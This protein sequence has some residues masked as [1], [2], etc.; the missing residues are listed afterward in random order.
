MSDDPQSHDEEQPEV[1]GGARGWEQPGAPAH[2]PQSYLAP[3]PPHQQPWVQQQPF[4]QYQ[5]QQQWGAAPA[6]YVDYVVYRPVK[7]DGFCVTS[8]ILGICSVTIGFCIF[9]ATV[10]LGIM[11]IVFGILGIRRVRAAPE[12]ST[13]SGLAIAGISLGSIIV[14]LTLLFIGLIVL[15]D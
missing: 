15:A 14:V 5:P 11:A 10:I 6:G 7:T 9:P 2:P 13:G 4:Q 3:P 12:S 8:I 1:P